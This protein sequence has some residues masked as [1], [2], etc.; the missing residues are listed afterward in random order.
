[1]LWCNG[2]E[3]SWERWDMGSILLGHGFDSARHSG[4]RI[5]HCSSCSL[6]PNFGLDLSPGQGAPY[7]LGRPKMKKKEKV[8]L[9]AR[10]FI[11][12]L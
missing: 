8:L 5:Q 9:G 1:M 4:S 7:A 10:G 12:C 11:K 2:S 6:S 3:V